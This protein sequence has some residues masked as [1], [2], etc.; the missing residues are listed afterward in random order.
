MI[1]R[2]LSSAI[3]DSL[4]DFPAVLLMGA[5]QVGKSTLVQDLCKNH[6]KANYLTLDDRRTLDFALEDPDALL[7]AFPPPLAIDEVQKAPDLLRA[8]KRKIDQNRKP[9]QFL[10]TGSANLLTLKNVSETLAGR[11]A[12]HELNPFSYAEQLHR[13]PLD[14]TAI[15]K[16]KSA[17]DLNDLFSADSQCPSPKL[18]VMQSVLGGG[19]P[20]PLAAKI[21]SSVPKY[22]ESYRKTYIERD[23]QDLQAIERLSDFSR[24]LD[25]CAASA[26]QLVNFAN[27]GRESMLP[28]ATLRR[29]A[30]ILEQTYQVFFVPPYFTNLRKR[31]LKNPKLY[32][33]DTGFLTH[34]LGVTDLSAIAQSSHWG[35]LLENWVAIELKKLISLQS[36]PVRIYGWRTY[37]GQ[38]VD[39]IIE[40]QGKFVAIEVKSSQSLHSVNVTSIQALAGELGEKIVYTLILYQGKTIETLREKIFACPIEIFFKGF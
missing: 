15:F 24:L 1:N 14:L 3:L 27:L 22:F 34:L 35:A 30:Q 28:Y 11:I 26:S 18:S 6:W 16:V 23:V 5:R 7:E 33:T 12:L 37:Q 19:Y 17:Q 40:M 32:W 25:L 31:I 4:I 8:V 20:V 36:N 9:G 21:K 38:E 10:L 13:K 39:F 29:Y 2:H